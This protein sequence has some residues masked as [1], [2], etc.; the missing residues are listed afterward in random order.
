[1]LIADGHGRDGAGAAGGHR[2]RAAL[3]EAAPGDVR[4]HL[5][6]LPGDDLQL[7]TAEV[8]DRGHPEG[9]RG[10]SVISAAG[11]DSTTSPA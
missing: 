3:G 10:R 2:D 6:R 1:M 9:C 11:P 7:A 8:A 5:R 4:A